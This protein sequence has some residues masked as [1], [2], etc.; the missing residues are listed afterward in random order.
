MINIRNCRHGRMMYYDTDAFIGRSLELYGEYSE[1]EPAVWSQILHPGMTTIEV[2]ANIGAHTI[3]LAKKLGPAGRLFAIEPQ[4]QLYQMLQGNL[5]LNEIK[6]TFVMHGAIGREMGTIAVPDVDYSK[7]GN[8]GG[9]S[10]GGISEERVPLSTIDHIAA[11]RVHFIKIDVEGMECDVI[12][13]ATNTLRRCKP[14]LYVENDRSSKSSELIEMLMLHDYRLW[15]HLPPLFN[16]QNFFGTV[17]NIFGA[18]VSVNML[19]IPSS[20]PA[21]LPGWREIKTPQDTS[22]AG[23]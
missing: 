2:G 10:L 13:G 3:F 19:C 7:D 20:Q 15:W 18:T 5:A 9:T 23:T 12:E 16:P 22:G 4:R 17:D 21:S 8:F 14:I 1:G 6:N 11:E